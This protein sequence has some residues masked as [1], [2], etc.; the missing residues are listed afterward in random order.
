ME[1]EP[2]PLDEYAVGAAFGDSVDVFRHL[3]D[4]VRKKVVEGL[5]ATMAK[6]R[7]RSRSRSRNRAEDQGPRS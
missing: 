2:E 5:N 3:P 1:V 4:E 7:R 6:R